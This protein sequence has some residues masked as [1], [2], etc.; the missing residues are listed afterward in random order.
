[1]TRED[2][3]AHK[4]RGCKCCAF[5]GEQPVHC[6]F[7]KHPEPALCG[8]AERKPPELDEAEAWCRDMYDVYGSMWDGD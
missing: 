5:Y 4:P 3:L 8:V 2:I 1:M 7:A 6:R